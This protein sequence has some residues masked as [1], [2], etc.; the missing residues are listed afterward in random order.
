MPELGDV[1]RDWCGEIERPVGEMWQ[2][3]HGHQRLC[4][5]EDCEAC[6]V[7]R[8]AKRLER[9]QLAV[10]GDRNL[11]GRHMAIVDFLLNAGRERGQASGR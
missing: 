8:R 6:G 4:R 2:Q 3:R 5:G 10:V 9:E 11:R 7:V 1:L